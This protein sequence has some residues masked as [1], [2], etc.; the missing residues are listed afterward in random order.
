MSNDTSVATEIK[1]CFGVESMPALFDRMSPFEEY[2][3]ATWRRYQAVMLSG[4]I[5]RATKELMGFSVGIAK[6]N[7][8]IIAWQR[9]Q[10]RTAGLGPQEEAEAV[11]VADFFEGFDAFSLALHVDSDLRPRKL[12]AG[13]LSLIDR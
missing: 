6:S 12:E 1:T 10:L 13:D 8:Y 2:L 9:Q 11:A 4:E 5:D 7:E 3:G